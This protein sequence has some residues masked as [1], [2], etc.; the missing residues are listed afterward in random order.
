M[1]KIAFRQAAVARAVKGAKQ[2]GLCVVGVEVER[3]GRIRVLTAEGGQ[4]P[5]EA[6]E[7]ERKMVEAFGA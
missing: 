2:A 6:Q 1:A 7:L 5:T 4:A 3:D